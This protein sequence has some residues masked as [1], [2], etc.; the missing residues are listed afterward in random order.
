VYLIAP[1]LLLTAWAV[2]GEDRPLP[3]AVARVTL[4]LGLLLQIPLVFSPTPEGSS[5]YLLHPVL[6]VAA[7]SV[8]LLAWRTGSVAARR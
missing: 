4:I 2:I 8:A 6:Q 5:V 1:L 3:L 7:L